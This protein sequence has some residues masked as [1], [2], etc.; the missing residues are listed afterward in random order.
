MIDTRFPT[1]FQIVLTVAVRD[2]DGSRCTSFDLAAGLGANPSFVRKLLGPLS[3]SGILVSSIGKNGG[4]RL[5][6]GACEI[7]LYDIYSAV[8]TDK[9]LWAGRGDVQCECPVSKHVSTLF[10]CVERQ[11]EAAVETAL[12]QLTIADTLR[13]LQELQQKERQAGNPESCPQ[14]AAAENLETLQD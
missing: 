12:S 1:A 8:I 7:S 5:G 3:Q 10:D 13:Q 9:K 6:R 11:A 4:I 14:G 2:Q